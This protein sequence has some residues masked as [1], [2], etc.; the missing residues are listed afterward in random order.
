[1][2]PKF[3]PLYVPIIAGVFTIVGAIIGS[4]TTS[5]FALRNQLKLTQQQ[6]RQ[7]AYAEI[8]GKKV[9]LKQLLVS[10]FE[11]Y[12]FSDYH[13]FLWK[14]ANKPSES[15]DFTEATRWMHKSEDLA[16][17]VARTKQSLF[18][19]IGLARA[20]FA[21]S[22]ELE[23]LTEAIFEFKS[24]KINPPSQLNDS[25]AKTAWRSQV[26]PELQAYVEKECG[27]PLEALLKYLQIN[28]QISV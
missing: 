9:L 5:R 23:R 27:G 12:V 15:L 10:R 16:L 13:E 8:M 3:Q 2:D 19:Y 22:P 28:F 21:P 17:E 20:V 25:A 14:I 24:P 6:D 26:I 7:R 1:V 11:A 4:F 18:E